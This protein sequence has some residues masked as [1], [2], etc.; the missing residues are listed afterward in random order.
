MH[1]PLLIPTGRCALLFGMSWFAVLDA[2]PAKAGM[3]IARRYRAT[4][5]VLTGPELSAVGIA[6]LRQPQHAPLPNSAAAIFA[7]LY[8]TG[9][10]AMA[11]PIGSD[12]IWLVAV[13]EGMVVASTDRL[14]RDMEEARQALAELRLS[15]P[16]LCVL[17]EASSHP[18]PD[19]EALAHEADS[20]TTL[21]KVSYA[22]QPIPIAAACAGLLLLCAV[23]ALW[24]GAA[25]AGLRVAMVGSPSASAADAMHDT[26]ARDA[27][28]TPIIHGTAGLRALLQSL[29]RLP[30]R[31]DGWLLITM[32]CEAILL[33]WDCSAEYMRHGAP[34]NESLLRPALPGW[35]IAFQGLDVARATW[36]ISS[37]GRALHGGRV[38]L[39]ADND[40]ALLPA[41]QTIRPAFTVLDTG[42]S[43]MLMSPVPPRAGKASDR[44]YRSRHLRVEGPLRSASLMVPLA[45]DMGWQ[46]V[47]LGH[48]SLEKPDAR[49]SALMI[50]LSGALY[51]IWS[52][53]A[54]AF[55]SASAQ[56]LDASL[57]DDHGL[58]GD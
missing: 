4:H 53:H 10:T 45:M 46:T 8:P 34:G 20:A 30:V 1:E 13:H 19:I 29:H 28:P 23:F 36:Q 58:P 6:V 42:P 25:P 21:R 15:F 41:L 37:P 32:R 2:Q 50:S 18:M 7:A 38:S 16:H 47:H 35:H 56:A 26:P 57:A 14:C 5:S 44:Q 48:R 12:A 54:A 24:F 43:E 9:A 22:F 11:M 33:R 51:E 49:Q 39:A 17:D 3:R 31:L 52:P 55:I 27:S 40:R